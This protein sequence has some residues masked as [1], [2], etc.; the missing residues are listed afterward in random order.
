MKSISKQNP[1]E[2]TLFD[3]INYFFRLF[4]VADLL[5]K[6]GAYKN[7]GVSPTLIFRKLFETAFLQKSFFMLLTQT[8]QKHKSDRILTIV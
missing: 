7:K 2:N 8:S 3:S 5:K 1:S 4:A 6:V